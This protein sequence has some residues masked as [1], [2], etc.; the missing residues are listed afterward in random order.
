MRCRCKLNAVLL[1]RNRMRMC[2][3]HIMNN[4]QGIMNNE[5]R[6]EKGDHNNV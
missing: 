4:E 2:G 5:K 3:R 6:N 1:S